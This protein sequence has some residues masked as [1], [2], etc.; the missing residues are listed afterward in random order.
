MA[1]DCGMHYNIFIQENAFV[2]ETLVILPRPQCV[3]P[4]VDSPHT[5]G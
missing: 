5:E 3:N 4:E 1:Y 2:C